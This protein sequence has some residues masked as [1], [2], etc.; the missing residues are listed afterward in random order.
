MNCT[1]LQR[2]L[3]EKV[4]GIIVRRSFRTLRR[5]HLRS[6]R[7]VRAHGGQDNWRSRAVPDVLVQ[8]NEPELDATRSP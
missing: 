3:M 5:R 2:W 1:P 4:L 6:G 7:R 8:N